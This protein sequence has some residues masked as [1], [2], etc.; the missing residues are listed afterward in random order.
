ML[1]KM[2]DLILLSILMLIDNNNNINCKNNDRISVFRI[3]F[4]RNLYLI[5]FKIKN[6]IQ[7]I[8]RSKLQLMKRVLF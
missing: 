4:N 3:G 2:K 6:Y 1:D 8:V 7:S 5:L